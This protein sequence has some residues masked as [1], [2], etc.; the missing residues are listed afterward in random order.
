[1]DQTTAA[2]TE[3][4]ASNM[5]SLTKL[6][7]ERLKRHEEAYRQTQ[8]AFNEVDE[9]LQAVD[10]QIDAFKKGQQAVPKK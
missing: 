7:N 3:A 5:R 9:R 2:L 8:E 6:L 10:T 1:M 4:Q